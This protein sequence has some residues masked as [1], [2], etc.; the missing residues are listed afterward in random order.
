[1]FKCIF[2][3]VEGLDKISQELTYNFNT[4]IT[5]MKYGTQLK[6]NLIN[7][8]YKNDYKNDAVKQATKQ[9]NDQQTRIKN[10]L[11]NLRESATTLITNNGLED[12]GFSDQTDT[13]TF[14]SKLNE[15]KVNNADVLGEKYAKLQLQYSTYTGKPASVN[16]EQYFNGK[17]RAG[18]F[19]T[20][21]VSN[22]L[23]TIFIINPTIQLHTQLKFQDSPPLYKIDPIEQIDN[24][25]NSSP[26]AAAATQ[27]ISKVLSDINNE[28][29]NRL[30]AE[31]QKKTHL[32]KET[33]QLQKKIKQLSEKNKKIQQLV[34]NT[35][36]RNIYKQ[37]FK[38][39]IRIPGV[40]SVN[41]YD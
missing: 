4:D 3:N 32:K 5:K 38:E 1:M 11:N 18:C 24:L 8:E 6:T 29:T 14:E 30:K 40:S 16:L 26:V 23:G 36:D 41:I 9:A 12:P 33:E 10:Q 37:I 28:H 2:A 17:S 34:L 21:H 19:T 27:T 22:V 15:A 39:N 35:Q 7:T 25:K 20:Y 13:K 31:E